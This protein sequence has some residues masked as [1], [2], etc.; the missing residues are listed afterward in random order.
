MK[1]IEGMHVYIRWKTTDFPL[2]KEDLPVLYLSF[3]GIKEKRIS[4]VAM[5]VGTLV[6]NEDRMLGYIHVRLLSFMCTNL[7]S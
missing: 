4:W 5:S 2:R 7:G 6:T 1:C 3:R